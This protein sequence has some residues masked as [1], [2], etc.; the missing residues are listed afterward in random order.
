MV[1]GGWVGMSGEC[2][3]Q[4]PSHPW[5]AAVVTPKLG[6]YTTAQLLHLT[7]QGLMDSLLSDDK[8]CG[9]AQWCP[10]PPSGRLLQVL[11]PAQAPVH[12]TST[13]TCNNYRGR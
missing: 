9:G 1:V 7:Y 11:R 6:M 2:W 8:I 3:Q 10:P 12:Y 4:W 5:H 13:G